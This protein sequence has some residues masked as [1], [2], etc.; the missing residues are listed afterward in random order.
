MSSF[1][2]IYRS[3]HIFPAILTSNSENQAP[4]FQAAEQK[5][6]TTVDVWRGNYND[7]VSPKPKIT[8]IKKHPDPITDIA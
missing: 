4:H 1:H 8:I 2:I 7:F 3:Q 6:S 5:R